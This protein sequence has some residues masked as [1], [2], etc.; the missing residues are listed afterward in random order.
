M[1]LRYQY[2]VH[3]LIQQ[4]KEIQIVHDG[5]TQT[6]L[7]QAIVFAAPNWT[8]FYFL[9]AIYSNETADGQP[10]QVVEGESESAQN[11]QCSGFQVETAWS[12]KCKSLNPAENPNHLKLELGFLHDVFVEVNSSPSKAH[13]SWGVLLK[14]IKHTSVV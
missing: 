10:E 4:H 11:S 7:I 3:L 1:N 5:T 9:R 2:K 14:Q 12:W 8:A 6:G 13:E